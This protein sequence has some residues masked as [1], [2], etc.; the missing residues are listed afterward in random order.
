MKKLFGFLL[1]MTVI[2][3]FIPKR[4][5]KIEIYATSLFAMTLGKTVDEI[6]DIKLNLY[7]FFHK[8]VDYLGILVQI[9][10]YPVVSLLFL[11]YFPYHMKTRYK[12][13]YILIWSVL[14]MVLEKISYHTKFFYYNRWKWWYSVLIYPVVYTILALNFSFIRKLTTR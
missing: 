7:G 11:N 8:G 5:S 1:I 9:I 10:S 3:V 4:L 14:T 13:F 2:A 12:V 6:L